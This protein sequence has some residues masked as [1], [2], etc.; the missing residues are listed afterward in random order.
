[1]NF[2]DLFFLYLFLPLCLIVYFI[3]P[4]IKYKNTVLVVFSLIFYAWGDVKALLLIVAYALLNFS[5]GRLIQKN[6]GT[7][8]A[9]L[10]VMLG[11]FADLG[12]L[13]VFKYTGFLLQNINGIFRT[14]VNVPK[15]W[16]PLGLSFFTFRTISYLLDVYWEKIEAEKYFPDFLLFTS[17]FP[18]TVAGPIVRYSTIG[19][20][21]KERTVNVDDMYV[22]F[23][24]LCVGLGK[25]VLIAD[26]LIT[27]VSAYWGN[28][29]M[30]VSSVDTWYAVI[31]YSMYVYFD[32]SGYSDMAIG[33]ARILG[34]HFEENFNYPFMCTSIAEFWQ[35]WH[36][37]L[38]SFFRDYLLYVPIFG[39][40]RR[41]GGLF[42]VWFCTGLWHGASWN[43]IIW[44]LYFG[45]F[46]LIETLLGKKR[47]KKIPKAVKH[48]YTKLVII[49]GFGIFYFTDIKQLG[50]FFRGILFFSK[51]GFV[52]DTFPTYFVN[53]IFLFL[54]ALVCCFPIVPFIQ[55]KLESHKALQ[56]A[57]GVAWGA[58][59]IA[60]LI[61]SSIFL[62]N[63][64]EHPFLYTNF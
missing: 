13:L 7:K 32:F 40:M 53:N 56:T 63:A 15:F 55:K 2:S 57:A 9:K 18:C 59:C 24:R 20:E 37:S 23:T 35:R 44:G 64:T 52:G 3:S 25:K 39:K 51:A 17:L 27:I 38:G 1:M 58:F 43:Y 29:A 62:V 34:F 5:L 12:M 45:L 46:I 41:Y 61:I 28:G 49:I 6:I 30:Y 26:N 21:L 54:I 48:I 31:V 36:I 33:I 10:F 60:L 42:L 16:V 19:A 14:S 47:L 8:K 11:L 50:Y 22:G 4:K